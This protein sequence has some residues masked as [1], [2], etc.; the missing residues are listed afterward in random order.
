MGLVEKIFFSSI[1][2]CQ[3]L[4]IIFCM[5]ITH[6]WLGVWTPSKC[7]TWSG[8]KPRYEIEGISSHQ[9]LLEY[10]FS[11]AGGW[12]LML[13]PATRTKMTSRTSF[14]FVEFLEPYPCLWSMLCLTDNYPAKPTLL[15]V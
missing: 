1:T 2:L 3:I 15:A 14:I 12:P 4:S 6:L 7:L 8:W 9:Y 11:S 10:C 13:L 5:I